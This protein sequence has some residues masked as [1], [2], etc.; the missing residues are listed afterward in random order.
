MPEQRTVEAVPSLQI[1]KTQDQEKD[2]SFLPS[3][4][5]I[6]N[7]DPRGWE[8]TIIVEFHG[9]AADGRLTNTHQPTPAHSCGFLTGWPSESVGTWVSFLQ[10]INA[11]CVM[12]LKDMSVRPG[13]STK[14]D[15]LEAGEMTESLMLR[16]GRPNKPL[17][18]ITEC[19]PPSNAACISSIPIEYHTLRRISVKKEL[20]KRPSTVSKPSDCPMRTALAIRVQIFL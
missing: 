20:R 15:R 12:R 18:A 3:S 14:V 1:S 4:L 5:A 17:L 8:C 7:Q 13:C 6:R 11:S 10:H 9:Q 19:D 16:G 2:S